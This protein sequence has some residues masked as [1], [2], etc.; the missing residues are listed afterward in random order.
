MDRRINLLEISA[1]NII[2]GGQ[3]FIGRDLKLLKREARILF[4]HNDFAL[5]IRLHK[6]CS[7]IPPYPFIKPYSGSLP[8][9]TTVFGLFIISI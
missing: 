4:T 9:A 2:G 5:F 8:I 7:F 3:V 6:L 1:T